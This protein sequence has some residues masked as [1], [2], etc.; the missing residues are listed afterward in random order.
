M[1]YSLQYTE[2]PHLL[3]NL[4]LGLLYFLMQFV[5]WIVVLSPDTF[6]AK[7]NERSRCHRSGDNPVAHSYDPGALEDGPISSVGHTHTHKK[8]ICFFR[9]NGIS[10]LCVS[11]N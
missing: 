5:N 9:L 1:S 11:H 4:F 7:G 2:F 6:I 10:W 8:Q 3:V